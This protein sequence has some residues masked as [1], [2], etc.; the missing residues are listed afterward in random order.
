MNDK[1]KKKQLKVRRVEILSNIFYIISLIFGILLIWAA[2]NSYK[3]NPDLPFYTISIYCMPLL[4]LLGL[5]SYFKLKRKSKTYWWINFAIAYV[6]GVTFW[7]IAQNKSLIA[8]TSP[9]DLITGNN[10]LGFSSSIFNLI[11]LAPLVIF[12]VA[13][14]VQYFL[15][16]W[17]LPTRLCRTKTITTI[18]FLV[19]GLS[20]ALQ[21]LH[22]AI[23]GGFLE[24]FVTQKSRI[25]C[26]FDELVIDEYGNKSMEVY[27]YNLANSYEEEPF[28]FL[29]EPET[30]FLDDMG[31]QISVDDLKRDQKMVLIYTYNFEGG[32]AEKVIAK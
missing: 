21:Q 24:N 17:S 16:I 19:V 28:S 32:I 18:A 8:T 13:A 22:L 26:F 7:K 30:K 12:V 9:L 25:D 23:R 3:L 20:L 5:V 29:I 14:L 15:E 4:A 1:E 2:Q 6:W 27:Y 31:K 11:A 10:L